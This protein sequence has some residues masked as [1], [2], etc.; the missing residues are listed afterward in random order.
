MTL[1]VMLDLNWDA[2]PRMM[3]RF[4]DGN[5][6][7]RKCGIGEGADSDGDEI[8]LAVWTIID[9]RTATGAEVEGDVVATVCGAHIRC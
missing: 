9:R 4:V 6:R 3:P 5:G 1:V 7:R 8:G 2:G